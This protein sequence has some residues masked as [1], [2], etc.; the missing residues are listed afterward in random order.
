VL[1]RWVSYQILEHQAMLQI[2]ANKNIIDKV[3]NHKVEGIAKMVKELRKLEAKEENPNRKNKIEILENRITVEE[4]ECEYAKIAHNLLY[5]YLYEAAIPFFKLDKLDLYTGTIDT[6]SN[7][8]VDNSIQ[9]A[10]FYRKVI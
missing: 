8:M 3:K 10:N 5:V 4:N 7:K 9:I 1:E 6:Y 2:L